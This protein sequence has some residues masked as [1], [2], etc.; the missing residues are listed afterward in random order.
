MEQTQILN[1]IGLSLDIVG[2]TIL[3]KWAPIQPY[4]EEGINRVLEDETVVDGKSI[5]E[6]NE[7]KQ[8][9]INKI[10]CWSKVGYAL[11]VIGFIFQIIS[12]CLQ[13]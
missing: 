5:S 9:K 4:L 11:I 2:V 8:T 7:D 13:S 12:N 3:L 10:R 1:I 6:H